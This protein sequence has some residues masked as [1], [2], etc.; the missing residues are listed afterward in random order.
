[1]LATEGVMRNALGAAIVRVAATV[2]PPLSLTVST[3][4]VPDVPAGTVTTNEPPLEGTV[5]LPL[6]A[7]VLKAITGF[8]DVTV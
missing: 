4:D 3:T 6:P 8:A 7:V 2:V 5:Q 1:M